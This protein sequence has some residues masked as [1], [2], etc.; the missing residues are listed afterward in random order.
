MVKRKAKKAAPVRAERTKS[1]T[2][3]PE[4]QQFQIEKDGKTL[5]W[6]VPEAPYRGEPN[7]RSAFVGGF[8]ARVE[9]VNHNAIDQGVPARFAEV[10]LQQAFTD[11]YHEAARQDGEHLKPKTLTGSKSAPAKRAAKRG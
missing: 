3:A 6:R 8:R 1:R 11:G 5:T 7:G 4:H 10:P 9:Q 2:P